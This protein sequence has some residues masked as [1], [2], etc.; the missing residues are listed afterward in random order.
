MNH[1]K[2]RLDD[3]LGYKL[4]HASRLISNR[5]NQNFK[6]HCFPVTY[7]QWQIM[8][9]LYEKDGQTQNNL[10]LLTEKD[11]PS[12]SR[13]ID[14]MIKR[15]LVK[16]IFHTTDRRVNLIYLT[17][18]SKKMQTQLEELAK[19]TIADASFEIDPEDMA[20]CLRV[21]DKI[22]ENLK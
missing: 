12:V 2:Y 17:E 14:N 21:L 11:Q 19:K 13:L 3:S 16:R 20:I 18:E 4:F 5:L 7:E 22:R 15:G 9:R 8:S 10:A 6:D 1:E